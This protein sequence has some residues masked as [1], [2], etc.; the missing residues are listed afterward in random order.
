MILE[1]QRPCRPQALVFVDGCIMSMMML[2]TA[3]RTRWRLDQVLP[4]LFKESRRWN[5][6]LCLRMRH[7]R[8]SCQGCHQGTG[9]LRSRWWWLL[10]RSCR[11][12]VGRSRRCGHETRHRTVR[13]VVGA[14]V[15]IRVLRMAVSDA[16]ASVR[17]WIV[18][19]KVQVCYSFIFHR[20][21]AGKVRTARTRSLFFGGYKRS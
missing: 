20:Q 19:R 14:V 12:T 3:A 13:I 5:C 7:G 8:R 9:R 16:A 1:R 18:R 10:P 11:R 17:V 21:F 2:V 6:M 15:V 4:F